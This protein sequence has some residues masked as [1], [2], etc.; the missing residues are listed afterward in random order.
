V[1]GSLV[2]RVTPAG[3]IDRRVA[4][5]V[6]KPTRPT[7]GGPRLSTLFITTIGGGSSHAPDPHEPDAGGLFAIETGQRGL[8]EPA[9]AG[10]PEAWDA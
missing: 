6:S 5:P 10:R 8:A 1:Y 2:L 9:F 7:F 4:L 3:E